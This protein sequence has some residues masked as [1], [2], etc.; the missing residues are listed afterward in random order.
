MV[1][2][3]LRLYKIKSKR[4]LKDRKLVERKIGII[5]DRKIW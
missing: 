5:Y 1:I 3:V 2:Y 4:K